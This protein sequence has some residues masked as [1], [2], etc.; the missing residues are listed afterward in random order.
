MIPNPGNL[1]TS[2]SARG[3][4]EAPR[5]ATGVGLADV[6]ALLNT[7]QTTIDLEE[8]LR[9]F[10][11]EVQRFVAHDG[12]LFEDDRRE[13][14]AELGERAHHACSYRLR[15][16]GNALGELRFTRRRRFVEEELGLLEELMCHL[17]HPLRNALFYQD[18][19]AAAHRDPLTGIGNRGALRRALQ[20]E[21]QLAQRQE[22]PLT[23]I[24]IDIDHFKQVND[25]HGH[26]IGD[27]VLK[28]VADN[29]AGALRASD[30]LFRFGGEE[31]VALLSNTTADQGQVVAERLRSAV[32]TSP[33]R[34]EEATIHAAVSLGLAEWAG[35]DERELFKRADAALYRAKKEGR[36]RVVA[37]TDAAAQ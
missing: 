14:M 30:Q 31:F 26:D 33:C 9:L 16:M 10:S 15:L 6:V 23:L 36:N 35:D 1:K 22:Q 13:L 7:L 5:Q 4:K 3:T 18:A 29:L 27:C 19:L 12:L 20:R 8:L 24:A 28:A 17:L 34:C 11:Q 21:M 32:A 2:D 37:A 25:D